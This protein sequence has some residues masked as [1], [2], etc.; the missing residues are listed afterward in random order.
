MLEAFLWGAAASGTLLLGAVIAYLATP[1]PRLNA[2]IMASGAGLL[3]GSVSYDLI[4]EAL[5]SSSLL[6]VATT[7]FLG[8]F[9]FIVGDRIL[10][11]MGAAQRKN[12][13]GAQADG[14]SK[15]IVMG[16][17]LD[18][19]PESFVLGLT[20]LQGGVSLPLLFSVAF[21]NLPEGMAS[22]SGLRIA[23]WPVKRVMLMWSLVVL[24]S[25]T[26]AAGYIMLDPDSGIIG[27]AG[28]AYAQAFAAGALLTMLV[29]TM[30]PESFE[31]ERDLTGGLVVLGFAGSLG[32]AALSPTLN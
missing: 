30:L 4:E 21:S 22:S 25:A 9:T 16:S 14:S 31:V 19:I 28:Q 10:D 2:V 6:L 5:K 7:F 13:K 20:V 23:G 26:A 29:D 15:A 12:T 32:L 1:G 17:V 27:P 11:R 24:V 3:L 8:S 18:G